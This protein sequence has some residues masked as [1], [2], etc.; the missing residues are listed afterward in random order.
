MKMLHLRIGDPV[1]LQLIGKWLR[2]GRW[3]M[4]WSC[5]RRR[6]YRK[7]GPISPVLANIHLHYVLD[8][9]FERVFV[10]R[11]DG[12]ACLRRFAEDYVTCFQYRAHAERFKAALAERLGKF[13][14]TIS[15]GKTQLIVFGRFA[16]ERAAHQGEHPGRFEFLGF[17]HVGGR[18]RHGSLSRNL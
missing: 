10:R 14:L 13:H 15:E 2:A 3:A 8:L 4:V 5:G 6:G 12:K 16:H 17:T 9:W 18:D 1:I 7:G 11:C